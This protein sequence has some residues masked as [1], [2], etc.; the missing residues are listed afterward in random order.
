[1]RFNK[2]LAGL[3]LAASV[4]AT[5]PASAAIIQLGFIVDSSGSITTGG[6][7]TIRTGLSNA[8]KDLI[9]ITGPDQYEVTVVS[10]S[11]TAIVRVSPTLITDDA[12]RTAVANTIAAMPFQNST[13]NFQAAFSAMTTA[14]TP[15]IG[16]A[17]FSYVNFATD[18]VQN[19]GTT[20]GTP[21][22]NALI[23]L[24]VDNISI[25]GIGSGVDQTDLT[26]NFCYPQP[27]DTTIPFNFPTQGFYLGI[28]STSDYE[29]AIR[30]KILV[31][32]GQ[33]PEPGTIALLGL[34][35][36]G[37]AATRRRQLNKA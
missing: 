6:W 36:A 25:E 31:V 28:A 19:A 3:A 5:A 23:A 32:T 16:Q 26:S 35:L 27:C 24:G 18:G 2:V 17:A 12:T 10:F 11:N 15:T 4:A 29:S 1:M 20:D 30:T 7:N 21:E 14:L 34:A 33:A 9:P 37:L 13:T 8:I 22:R